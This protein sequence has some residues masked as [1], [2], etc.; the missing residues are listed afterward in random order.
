[1][2]ALREERLI[3]F[4]HERVGET[5]DLISAWVRLEWISGC[6]FDVAQQRRAAREGYS[7]RGRAR[8]V[9]ELRRLRE[10][11]CRGREASLRRGRIPSRRAFCECSSRNRRG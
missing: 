2:P 8:G 1:M 5:N 4:W 9:P 6:A 11:R 3:Y 7:R 10:R